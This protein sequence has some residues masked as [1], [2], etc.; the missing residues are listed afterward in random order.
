MSEPFGMLLEKISAYMIKDKPNRFF[1]ADIATYKQRK[2]AYMSRCGTTLYACRSASISSYQ[3]VWQW[4]ILLPPYEISAKLQHTT[5]ARN[6]LFKRMMKT[7]G[8]H[9]IGENKDGWNPSCDTLWGRD[10]QLN[11]LPRSQEEKWFSLPYSELVRRFKEV[12][13]S[14]KKQQQ[15]RYFERAIPREARKTGV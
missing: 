1:I 2:Y 10:C 14:D 7:S 3:R 13:R 8:A 15:K 5:K 4:D 9:S 6:C 12:C 11:S